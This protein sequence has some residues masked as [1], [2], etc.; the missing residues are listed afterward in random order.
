VSITDRMQSNIGSQQ[1]D[2]RQDLFAGEKCMACMSGQSSQC[3]MGGACTA[4]STD[5]FP[6][7]DGTTMPCGLSNCG[8]PEQ[9]YLDQGAFVRT[10]T[11]GQSE[12]EM[13]A[14]FPY[15]QFTETAVQAAQQAAIPNAQ[16]QYFQDPYYFSAYAEG[17]ELAGVYPERHLVL[18][19]EY[20]NN[21][22]I[23]T[24]P[25]GANLPITDINAGD[26]YQPYESQRRP[27][28]PLMVADPLL[29]GQQSSQSTSKVQRKHIIMGV[30][31][32]GLLGG[33]GYVAL[34]K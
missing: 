18:R 24:N 31:A 4:G 29:L 13:Q 9:R 11:Y 12:A 3:P 30:V 34:K 26:K 25:Q 2:I 1:Y 8:I 33:I 22:I 20:D 7:V 21:S 23:A 5:G 10:S 14:A 19:D 28:V 32:V 27:L 16:Y 15:A 17:K 6:A